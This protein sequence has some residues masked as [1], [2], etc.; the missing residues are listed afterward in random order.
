MPI[1]DL[2]QCVHRTIR[3]PP[4]DRPRRSGSTAS[5]CRSCY[6]GSPTSTCCRYFAHST[7]PQLSMA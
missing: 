4:S 7:S 1:I 6:A 2:E 3:G 5:S